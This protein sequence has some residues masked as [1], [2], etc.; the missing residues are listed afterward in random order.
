MG[1]KRIRHCAKCGDS[2][3]KPT[4]LKCN[5]V[6]GQEG[7]EDFGKDDPDDM[8]VKGAEGG[9]PRPGMIK[10]PGLSRKHS[11]DRGCNED[12][13]TAIEDLVHC[14]ANVVL[15]PPGEHRA[16]K[17]T[18]SRSRSMSR[19]SASSSPSPVGRGERVPRKQRKLFRPE[20]TRKPG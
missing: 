16:R 6:V 4:G 7:T 18:R 20:Q 11:V 5:K 14:M 2:H 12:R 19:S 10:E 1:R 8:D 3:G 9:Y 17:P 13:L 15:Q